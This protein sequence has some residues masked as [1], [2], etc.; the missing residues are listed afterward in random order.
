[1][2]QDSI[3]KGIAIGFVIGVSF[4][5]FSSLNAEKMIQNPLGRQE[6][7]T[8][9]KNGS[10][11][12]E[13]KARSFIQSMGELA[14]EILM[15]AQTPSARFEAFKK[16]LLKDF[17]FPAIEQYLLGADNFGKLSPPQREEYKKLLPDYIVKIYLSKFDDYRKGDFSKENF[18]VKRTFLRNPDNPNAGISVLSEIQ[19]PQE[20]GTTSLKIEWRVFETKAGLKVLD[21]FVNDLSMS[22]T[23]KDEFSQIVKKGGINL[24]LEK[25]EEQVRE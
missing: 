25:L 8:P 12:L 23:K 3:K 7:I 6:R 5:T 17:D 24:L 14:I 1:M 15:G 22:Q 18:Q 19:I 4:F 13:E 2:V 11:S 9:E 10:S 20:S 16:I 21:V